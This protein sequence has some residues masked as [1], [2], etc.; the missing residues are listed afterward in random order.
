MSKLLYGLQGQQI[1]H[2]ESP[3]DVVVEYFDDCAEYPDEPLGKI[4]D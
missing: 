4:V 1:L 2:R 3:E